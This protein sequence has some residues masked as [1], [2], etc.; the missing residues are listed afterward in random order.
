MTRYRLVI[1]A[2]AGT[3]RAWCN[4]ALGPRVRGDDEVSIAHP[5][6]VIPANAGTQSAGFALASDRRSHQPN[7]KA[8]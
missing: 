1:P 6:F 8:A 5:S 4:L 3:Q 7:G 2:K